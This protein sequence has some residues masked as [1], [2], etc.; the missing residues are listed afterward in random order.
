MK[1]RVCVKRWEIILPRLGGID[2][3]I[4]ITT[5]FILIY[6]I[7]IKVVDGASLTK[8][9]FAATVPD[10]MNSTHPIRTVPT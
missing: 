1:T 10:S 6:T 7:S 5:L 4:P 2:V 9:L 3:S 8:T